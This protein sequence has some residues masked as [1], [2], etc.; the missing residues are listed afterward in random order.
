[1]SIPGSIK[2]NMLEEHFGNTRLWWLFLVSFA[3]CN[4]SRHDMLLLHFTVLNRGGPW[5]EH[6][7]FCLIYSR[8]D[9]NTITFDRIYVHGLIPQVKHHHH[10]HAWYNQIQAIQQRSGCIWRS[11]QQIRFQNWCPWDPH[12]GHKLE[13]L[14]IEQQNN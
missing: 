1:M 2:A 13:D 3:C 11:L 4:S 5:W 10:L 14:A 6:E 9:S 8:A 12:R 7:F